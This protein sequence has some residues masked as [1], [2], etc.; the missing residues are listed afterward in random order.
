MAASREGLE[1]W[2]IRVSRSLNL[3]VVGWYHSHPGYI[4]NPSVIGALVSDTADLR[5]QRHYEELLSSDWVGLIF[6]VFRKHSSGV[7]W[8]Y[9]KH[10]TM[11]LP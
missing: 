5:T 2:P 1:Q 11:G 7:S 4:A 9:A 8:V 6:S 10:R 3:S